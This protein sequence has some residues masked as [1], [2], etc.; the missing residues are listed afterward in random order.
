MDDDFMDVMDN[1]FGDEFVEEF[2]YETIN[3]YG[4][5]D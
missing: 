2:H 1:C 3:D 5:K 4:N